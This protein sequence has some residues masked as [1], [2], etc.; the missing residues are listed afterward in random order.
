MKTKNTGA[1]RSKGAIGMLVGLFLFLPARAAED[2]PGFVDNMIAMQYFMHK[3]GLSIRADNLELADFYLHEIE[4]IL[5]VVGEVETYGEMPVGELSTAMLGPAFHG[6]EEAVDSG[7]SGA[8]LAA[9][10]TVINS[11]N[12]CHTATNFGYIKI[13]DRSTENVYM[14]DFGK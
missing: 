13:A 10:A 11:C 12:A 3:A 8:A 9:F 14:Q 1:V 2:V 6:L 4:E 7:D 5:E